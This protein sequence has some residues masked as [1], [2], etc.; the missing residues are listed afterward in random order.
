MLAGGGCTR[1]RCLLFQ[2]P[3]IIGRM[4]SAP[5]WFKKLFFLWNKWR[6]F[7]C[8]RKERSG[9][10][11]IFLGTPSIVGRRIASQRLLLLTEA[12]TAKHIVHSRECS[13]DSNCITE[14]PAAV[15]QTVHR[16][17]YS[18]SNRPKKWILKQDLHHY[19]IQL[20]QVYWPKSVSC[21][22]ANLLRED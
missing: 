5:F 18:N 22:D 10:N 15:D 12:K 2:S 16:R 1:P 11:T 17:A 9:Y 3:Q 8:S 13:T 20:L 4:K 19:K 6:L 14:N 21:T 7:R